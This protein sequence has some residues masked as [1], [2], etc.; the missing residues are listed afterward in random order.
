MKVEIYEKPMCCESGL[1]GAV[2]DST[3]LR[4]NA[5]IRK[6]RANGCDIIRYNLQSNPER[7]VS[8]KTANAYLAKRGVE[9][10]PIVFL[11]G[12]VIKEGSYPTNDELCSYFGVALGEL[13]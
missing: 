4:I 7:F 6:L 5:I 13:R 10:L 1:C 8:N 2:V 9:G 3:L 12:K 11:D